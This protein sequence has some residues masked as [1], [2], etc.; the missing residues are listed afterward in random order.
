MT[1]RRL[2]AFASKFRR[3][4]VESVSANNDVTLIHKDGRRETLTWENFIAG[5]YELN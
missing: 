5:R 1:G 4:K 3:I 2:A